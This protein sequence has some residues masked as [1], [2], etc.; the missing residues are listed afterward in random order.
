MKNG[1]GCCCCGYFQIQVGFSFALYEY[2]GFCYWFFMQFT[3]VFFLFSSLSFSSRRLHDQRL[4]LHFENL[5][6]ILGRDFCFNII[7]IHGFLQPYKTLCGGA[8]LELVAFIHAFAVQKSNFVFVFSYY[9]L[10]MEEIT[11]I[12]LFISSR[13]Y[14]RCFCLIFGLFFMFILF[15]IFFFVQLN[16]KCSQVMMGFNAMCCYIHRSIWFEPRKLL[17]FL[18]SFI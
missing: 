16:L 3:F 8:H 15:S 5:V 18:S 6:S 7:F 10:L 17:H 1:C 12:N 9:S 13:H 2:I 4:Q 14:V 11:H